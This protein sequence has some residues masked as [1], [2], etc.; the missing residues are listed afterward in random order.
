MHLEHSAPFGDAGRDRQTVGVSRCPVLVSTCH[1]TKNREVW[2]NG[3][4]AWDHEHQ[5]IVLVIIFICALLG[6]NPM[7]S[8][9]A[10]HIGSMGNLFCR[11]CSVSTG[12]LPPA[13]EQDTEAA[14]VDGTL[15][16]EPASDSAASNASAGDGQQQKRKWVESMAEMVDR[17]KRFVK[18]RT[19]SSGSTI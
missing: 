2:E 9:F 16:S 19:T 3:I 18:V 10:C 4:L 6:D 5:E 13:D 11:I 14:D 8:E 1:S 7:Q 15:P 17:I 12:P